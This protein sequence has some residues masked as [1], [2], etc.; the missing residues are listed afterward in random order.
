MQPTPTLRL[1]KLGINTYRENVIYIREDSFV[2]R[3]E[4]FET[5]ARIKVTLGDRSILATLHT[6]ETGLLQPDEASL[7]T[8]AWQLLEAQEGDQVCLAHPKPLHSLNFI[9]AKVYGHELDENAIQDIIK[10]IQRGRLSDVHIAAFIAAC[11]GN[12]MNESEII[13]LTKAMVATG[14]TLQWQSDL[15]V[16]KHSVGGLPGNRTTPIVVPIVA[17]FGLTIPKTSSRAITSPAGT[18]DTVEV[19]TPVDISIN[20]MRKVV[21]QEQGCMVWGGAMGLSPVDDI[22]ISIERALDLD[23]EAQMVASILSKKISAGSTHVVIDVPIGITAKVRNQ[24]S[25]NLLKHLLEIIGGIFG[26]TIQTLFTDGSQPV[27]RGIGPALEAI[28]VL[29]VLQNDSKAPSHLR[30]RALALAGL[31]LEHSPR[32]QAGSGQKIAEEIL[33]SGKAWKKFQSI[34]QAQG[35]LFE[36]PVA[37]HIHSI[38]APYAGK[39]ISVDNR[40]LARTAKLA[41]APES[42]AAGIKL[43]A[44]V[45]TD[46]E[47]DQ[48]LFDIH[49]ETQAELEYAMHYYEAEKNILVIART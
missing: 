34:C 18:A 38:T 5:Q 4:G 44:A 15:V 32:V 13:S 23:S 26:L 8:Y 43:F 31:L 47:Q 49:S 19:L 1:K 28:D 25:A 27:G 7:S 33:T 2:C 30:N 36:P 42:K 39:I 3:S 9:R 6:V 21:E 24:E 22:L 48:P 35:G 10:D 29:Q 12:R 17:A 46:V 41:G 40:R 16:D 11:A 20:H 14:D 37:K 45:D